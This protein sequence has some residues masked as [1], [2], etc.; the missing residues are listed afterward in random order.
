[1]S[2]RFLLALSAVALLLVVLAVP[3]FAQEITVTADGVSPDPLT[4]AVGDT[5]AFTNTSEEEVRF[6]DDGERWDSGPLAPG[7]VFS[8]TFLEAG[9]ITY[10]TDD[11]SRSGVIIVG[12]TAPADVPLAD[13]GAPVG[14][15][16]SGALG[17]FAAGAVLL[18][19][20]A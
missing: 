11:G 17:A 4:I 5:V 8:I 15:L 1:M 14:V 6:F 9:R 3:A 18:R 20:T 13:T 2:T 7:D 12:E 19:R 10:T 16:L